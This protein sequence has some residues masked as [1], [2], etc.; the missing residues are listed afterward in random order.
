MIPTVPK[1]LALSYHD[2]ATEGFLDGMGDDQVYF[3]K[4]AAWDQGQDRRLYV[5]G[6]VTRAIYLELLDILVISRRLST[7]STW[8]PTWT[9]ANPAMEAR[10]NE[11]VEITKRSIS[12]PACLALGE[13]LIGAVKIVR[14]TPRSLASAI[15][16]AGGSAPGNL[17]D[18]LARS[19]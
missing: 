3:F 4:V 8:V 2:G 9:F 15:A 7:S 10:A 11:I 13:E 18:W 19:A 17:A 14:P 1:V 5:L 16:L 6:K 12:N